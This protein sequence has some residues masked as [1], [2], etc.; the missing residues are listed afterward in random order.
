VGLGYITRPC[1]RKK[2]G[3][4]K[5]RKGKEGKEGGKEKKKNLMCTSHLILTGEAPWPHVR[6]KACSL[7]YAQETS[8]LLLLRT[9]HL[10]HHFPRMPMSY[11]RD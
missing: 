1:F 10:W 11:T 3:R 5:G 2:G 6:M 7:S 9:Y 4:K 8:S